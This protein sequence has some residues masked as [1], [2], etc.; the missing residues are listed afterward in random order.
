MKIKKSAI[1][2][3]DNNPERYETC[4]SCKGTG[5]GQYFIDRFYDGGDDNLETKECVF[6]H[7]KGYNEIQDWDLRELST[8]ELNRRVLEETERNYGPGGIFS[9]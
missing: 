7:G 4:S 1:K 3:V 2:I 8:E 6:C 5:F 9:R